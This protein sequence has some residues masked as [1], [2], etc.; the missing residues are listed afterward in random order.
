MTENENPNLANL[1]S[2]LSEKLEN[3]LNE[4]KEISE[5]VITISDT[6]SNSESLSDVG[7]EAEVG[8]IVMF[9]PREESHYKL[10]NG[11]EKA[12]AIITQIFN[13]VVNLTVF[14]ADPNSNNGCRQAWSIL[15][16][17]KAVEGQ[18][19]WEDK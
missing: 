16:K 4:K 15:H 12:P 19:Y 1:E 6:K 10:P 11:M 18:A 9:I 17:S 2:S 8:K 13:N 5:D 14:T 3:L 7:Y